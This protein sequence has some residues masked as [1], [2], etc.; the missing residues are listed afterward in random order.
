ML[1]RPFALLAVV[2]VAATLAPAASAVLARVRVEGKTT[3][4]FGATE[5]RVTAAT[6]LEALDGAS[7]AGEFY[8]HVKQFAFGPFVDQIGRF[9]AAGSSGWVFKVNGVSPPVGADQVALKDGDRVLWY[10]ADFGPQGGP[11]TLRLARRP[12]G[13]YQVFAQD[14]QGKETIAA[15]AAL[16]VDGRRVATTTGRTCLGPH[17][18]LVRAVLAG[19]VRSNAVR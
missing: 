2:A 5:P 13:C 9:P 3:T 6:A 17:R 18:G 19:V 7:R 15:G 1:R 16:K 10:W 4:I 14:D 8:Y 12:G 11:P